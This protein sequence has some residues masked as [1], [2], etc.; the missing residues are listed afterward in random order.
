MKETTRVGAVIINKNKDKVLLELQKIGDYWVFPKGG[1]EPGET[2]LGALKREIYEETGIKVFALDRGFKKRIRYKF[3]SKEGIISVTV[4]YY[5]MYTDQ[6]V[7]ITHPDEILDLRWC[8]FKEAKKYLKF[9]N[10]K[11]LLKQV[12]KYLNAK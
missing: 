9:K 1:I 6:Q 7:K 12:I 11:E 4:V 2:E 3:N 5:L 10:Q 8:S